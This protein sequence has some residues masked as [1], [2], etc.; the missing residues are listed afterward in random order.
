MCGC[1]IFAISAGCVPARVYS[2]CHY[3]WRAGPCGR[4]APSLLCVT[5]LPR[6]ATNVPRRRYSPSPRARIV[7]GHQLRLPLF[8]AVLQAPAVSHPSLVIDEAELQCLVAVLIHRRFIRGYIS[9]SPL[10]LVVSKD[11]PFPR[12]ADVVT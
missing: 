5:T 6:P 4:L 10:V 7:G 2:A 9:H 8:A 12:I 11:R 1:A 3:A